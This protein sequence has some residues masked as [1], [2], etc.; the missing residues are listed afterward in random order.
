MKTQ[1]WNES[2]SLTRVSQERA[3]QRETR[4]NPNF[5]VPEHFL[6]VIR[7][8][9]SLKFFCLASHLACGQRAW[10]CGMLWL[11]RWFCLPFLVVFFDIFSIFFCNCL[12][13]MSCILLFLDEKK[14]RSSH[15]SALKL[16]MQSDGLRFTQTEADFN[17]GRETGELLSFSNVA[18]RPPSVQQLAV[19]EHS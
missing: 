3:R 11:Y 16:S 18:F 6:P 12:P 8:R 7:Q 17:E 4:K 14:R 2:F 13:W 9:S 15:L 19:T 10:L 5:V 1:V